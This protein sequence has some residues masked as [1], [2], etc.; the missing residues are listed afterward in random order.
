MCQIPAHPAGPRRQ[1]GARGSS[2]T[3]GQ[4]SARPRG[5]TLC[6]PLLQLLSAAGNAIPVSLCTGRAEDRA[7]EVLGPAGPLSLQRD[8][9]PTSPSSPPHVW[10]QTLAPATLP[11]QDHSR[12]Y[13][14]EQ[15][16]QLSNLPKYSS[17]QVT[18]KKSLLLLMLLMENFSPFAAAFKASRDFRQTLSC[19]ETGEVEAQREGRKAGG[20]QT[21]RSRGELGLLPSPPPAAAAHR[22]S[23]GSTSHLPHLLPGSRSPTSSLQ[24]MPPTP[25]TPVDKHTGCVQEQGWCPKGLMGQNHLLC[26]FSS[27]PASFPGDNQKSSPSQCRC[28]QPR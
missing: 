24:G 12:A 21:A 5:T 1:P 13:A 17:Y 28:R 11:E 9:Q 7:R 4:A 6:S 3:R 16:H 10:P 22:Q 15:H 2:A 27:P 8:A 18:G 20:E 25:G 14:W 23:P 26:D 19:T